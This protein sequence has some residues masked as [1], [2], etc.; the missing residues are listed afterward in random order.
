MQ[1][2]AEECYTISL[3]DKN[4]YLKITVRSDENKIW[5]QRLKYGNI[6]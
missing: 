1:L 5:K 6:H 3:V 2:Q 4:K